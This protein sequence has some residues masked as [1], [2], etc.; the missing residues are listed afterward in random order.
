MCDDIAVGGFGINVLCP[1]TCGIC[2][3][4]LPTV[5]PTLTPTLTPTLEP[6]LQPTLAPTL[7]PT[8]A[9]TTFLLK[10]RLKIPLVDLRDVSNLI[11]LQFQVFE[12]LVKSG[13]PPSAINDIKVISG[14]V[15]II[16]SFKPETTLDES[17]IFSGKIA[18][19]ITS[20]S[21]NFTVNSTDFIAN[22]VAFVG[23]A[24]PPPA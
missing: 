13:I 9:P 23:F 5:A 22:N 20:F 24:P 16:I 14:S 21:F 12:F 2:E 15:I 1:K 6:T 17:R 8:L 18:N 7:P 11:N 4:P 10:A 3:T 19:A